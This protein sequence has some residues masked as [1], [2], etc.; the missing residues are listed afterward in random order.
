MMR[1]VGRVHTSATLPSPLPPPPHR[2]YCLPPFPS[3]SLILRIP[4]ATA[5]IYMYVRPN[6]ILL[7]L[8]TSLDCRIYRPPLMTETVAGGGRASPPIADHLSA[9]SPAR[10]H[11][12]RPSCLLHPPPNRAINTLSFASMRFPATRHPH[13]Q[14]DPSRGHSFGTEPPQFDCGALCRGCVSLE[15]PPPPFP[16]LP[17]PCLLGHPYPVILSGH[18][19]TTGP[20]FP[21][22]NHCTEVCGWYAS[23]PPIVPG[24]A[25]LNGC[26]YAD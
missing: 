1:R 8:D 17:L 24:A 12:R 18:L 6:A 22:A 26:I 9:F 5:P 10:V 2:A 21:A 15:V 19:P 11:H 7:S 20:R 4:I 16:P 3:V 23:R 13:R 14:M 25:A